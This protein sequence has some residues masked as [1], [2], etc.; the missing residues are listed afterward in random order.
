MFELL[1]IVFD[2]VRGI[3]FFR[4]YSG[5]MICVICMTDWYFNYGEND[6]CGLLDIKLKSWGNLG[7]QVIFCSIICVPALCVSPILST[8]HGGL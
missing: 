1:R 4:Q 2:N 8:C 5:F 7:Q 3:A 6:I